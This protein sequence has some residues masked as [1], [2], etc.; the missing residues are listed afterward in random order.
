MFGRH[1]D[2]KDEILS[3]ITRQSIDVLK[4]IQVILCLFISLT[5][6]IDQLQGWCEQR[7][8]ASYPSFETSQFISP[9][10]TWNS[11]T[12]CSVSAYL[13]STWGFPALNNVVLYSHW[14]HIFAI[15]SYFSIAIALCTLS[16]YWQVHNAWIGESLFVL[17]VFIFFLFLHYH[18]TSLEYVYRV[19]ER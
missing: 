11:L 16:K 19:R 1:F 10:R 6:G 12:N 14:C 3:H 2:D 4:V 8:M 13:D 18:P 7:R 15:Q 9:Q 17:I 5:F